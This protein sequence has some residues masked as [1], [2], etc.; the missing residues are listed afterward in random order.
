MGTAILIFVIIAIPL[1]ILA[2]IYALYDVIFK[3]KVDSAVAAVVAPK[4]MENTQLQ[5]PATQKTNGKKPSSKKTK[6]KRPQQ[7][8][9]K[10]TKKRK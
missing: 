4:P 2:I 10:R 5:K 8:W 7:R 3:K 9:K 6:K 1:S